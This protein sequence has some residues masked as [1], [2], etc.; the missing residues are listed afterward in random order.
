MYPAPAAARPERPVSDEGLALGG[1]GRQ[2][3]GRGKCM[4]GTAPSW[5][6]RKG[7]GVLLL[8]SPHPQ[9]VLKQWPVMASPNEV[10]HPVTDTFRHDQ[11]RMQEP[12]FRA[13]EIY[14]HRKIIYF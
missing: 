11:R 2:R 5:E 7:S 9:E 6:C 1:R 3:G 8:K 14:T 4:Q 12:G 10:I 13:T